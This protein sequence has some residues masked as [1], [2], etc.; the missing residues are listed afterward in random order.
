MGKRE[1]VAGLDIGS[2]R[3]SCVIGE[4]DLETSKLR[5]LGGASLPCRGLKGG[6]VINLQETARVVAQAVEEAEAKARRVV[7]DV[8]VG[9]R[10]NHLQ[11]FNN[12]GAFNIARTDKE[13]TTEDVASVIG[14]AKAIPLSPDREIL[15]VVPQ[16]YSLDRQKGVPHPVGMEGA[17]LEVEVHIVTASSAHLNNVYKSVSQAGF[18]VIE[19]VYSLLALGETLVTPEEKDLGS[20]LIDLGGQSISLGVYCEGALRYSREVPIGADF[21]TRDLAVGLRTSITTAERIKLEHGIAHPSLLDGDPEIGFNGIDGRSQKLVKTSAMMGII[22][23][24]VEEIFTVV[25]QEIQNSSLAEMAAAGGAIVTGGGSL[26]RGT[27]EAAEQIL[28]MP[29]RLGMAHPDEVEGDESWLSPTYATAVSLLQF[30]SRASWASGN[31]RSVAGARR[32]EWLRRMIGVFE[33]IF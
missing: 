3:V 30:P 27:I 32:P 8:Y 25:A 2:S 31:G 20:I 21:I 6:V 10:G 23:P 13:I 9:V 7:S 1:A 15:H 16:G 18:K 11:S 26:M 4:P 5:I 24:R 17:L 12:R 14:N 22:L 28:E 29:V 33:G 19:P